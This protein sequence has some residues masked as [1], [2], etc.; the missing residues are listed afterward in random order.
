MLNIGLDPLLIFGVGP[1]PQLGITGAAIATV[2]S[3]ASSLFI[4]GYVIVR[5]EKLITKSLG[6]FRQVFRTWGQILFVGLPAAA[7]NI[8][9][10]LSMGIITRMVSDFGTEAVAGFGAATR[11]ES[12]ALVFTLALSMVL[13]PFV[14]QNHGAGKEDRVIRGQRVSSLFSLLW[15]AMVLLVFLVAAGP[16]ASIFNDTPEVVE[17]TA[18]YLRIVAFSYGLLGIV[19]LS[20][21]VFNGL[22]KPLSAAGVAFLRL[23][24][25]YIP[26]AALGKHLFGLQGI[27]YGAAIANGL[28]GI[29][30]F[31]WVTRNRNKVSDRPQEVKLSTGS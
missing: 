29:A 17:V 14:G 4:V 20:T 22:K 16:I 25:F 12:F 30:G 13:T 9:L 6:R 1:F 28:S 7:A 18:L 26:L 24:V 3:R 10:P 11:V 31:L 21:A 2:I 19:N 8:L 23:F 27:F 15:G 5:R